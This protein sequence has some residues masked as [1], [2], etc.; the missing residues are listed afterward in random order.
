MRNVGMHCHA[1]YLPSSH[2]TSVTRLGSRVAR[3][4]SVAA[5]AAV[6]IGSRSSCAVQRN[7]KLFYVRGRVQD[8]GSPDKSGAMHHLTHRAYDDNMHYE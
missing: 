4:A 1:D 8:M 5:H 6:P 2:C 7:H 3:R